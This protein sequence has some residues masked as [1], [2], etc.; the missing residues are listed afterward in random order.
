MKAQS[1]WREAWSHWRTSWRRN[2]RRWSDNWSVWW[3]YKDPS[4]EVE[5]DYL[6]KYEDKKMPILDIKLAMKSKIVRCFPAPSMKS[7]S[8]LFEIYDQLALWCKGRVRNSTK[9]HS[10][11]HCCLNETSTATIHKNH[12]TS[13]CRAEHT[14][15]KLGWEGDSG[16]GLDINWWNIVLIIPLYD[17]EHLNVVTSQKTTQPS[18]PCLTHM[19]LWRRS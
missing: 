7:A 14:E 4:I 15:K 17:L 10:S 6:S 2:G 16:R 11:R 19:N 12:A 8:W 1:N 9:H 18:R 13:P 3:K 5:I